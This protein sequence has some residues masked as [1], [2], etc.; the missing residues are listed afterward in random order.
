[1]LM[2]SYGTCRVDVEASLKL[3]V[4]EVMPKLDLQTFPALQPDKVQPFCKEPAKH[5]S[6]R[7]T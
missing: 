2:G 1:M 4:E 5:G 7:L 3:F 6:S